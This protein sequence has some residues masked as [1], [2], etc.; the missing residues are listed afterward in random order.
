ML[1]FSRDN[2]A[3]STTRFISLS[4]FWSSTAAAEIS[5]LI[6]EILLSHLATDQ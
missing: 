3:L 4:Y 1:F 6:F 5:S 2:F